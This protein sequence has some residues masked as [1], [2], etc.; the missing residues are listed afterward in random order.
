MLCYSLVKCPSYTR[1][2]IS[3]RHS[4]KRKTRTLDIFRRR[5]DLCRLLSKFAD[6]DFTEV[7]SLKHLREHLLCPSCILL[8]DSRVPSVEEVELHRANIAL[9]A[10]G[11]LVVQIARVLI[12]KISFRQRE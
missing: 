8:G 4:P 9:S 10:R 12:C 11:D 1:R 6:G 3:K 7:L 5:E 2:E